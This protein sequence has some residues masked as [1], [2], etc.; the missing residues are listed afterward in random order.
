MILLTIFILLF[1][2]YSFLIIYYW[3]A[4]KAIPVYHPPATTPEIKISVI[5]PVRNE[6]ENIFHLL[7]R[8]SQQSYP[9][10]LVEVIVVDDHSTDDTASIVRQFESVKL[11]QLTDEHL[12]SYKKKAIETGIAAASG[13]LIITTDADC[14]PAQNWLKTIVAFKEDRKSV[15]IA[16]P[17]V[18]ECNSSLLEVFQSMD[19][20]TLQGITGASV[21]KNILS[22]CNGANLAYEKK[23]FNSVNG[24]AG[25][26]HIAS[27]DDML[28]MH[29]IWKQNP[30]KVHYLKSPDAI[31]STQPMKTWS[32]FFNQRIRWASKAT[33]YGDKRIIA[34]LVLVYLFN[35]F[36]LILAVA[37]CWYPIYWLYLLV[38]WVAKTIVELP[39]FLSV[40]DFFKKRWAVKFLFFFQP[41]HITYTIISGLFGQFGKYE[42]KGRMVR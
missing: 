38:F 29:K 33:N 11:I 5:I 24:F 1:V 2:L 6:E 42:W 13:D 26:D 3:Q 10:E 37:G 36:Y 21:Q 22:M 35:L 27:G 15:F 12:N 30:D 14:Q 16:A 40:A 25:I 23:I 31:V 9:D 7:T 18:Q 4:W 19:F 41:L 34:V 28:L 8:L 17:V 20:M 32:A 39:F